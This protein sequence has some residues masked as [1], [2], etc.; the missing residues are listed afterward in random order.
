MAPTPAFAIVGAVNHGKSSVVS[1]LAE[2]D[3]VSVSPMPGE[4]VENK[5]FA[6]RDL[7]VF[8]DTPGFQNARKALEDIRKSPTASTPLESFA[9][10]V[11]RHRRNPEFEA[12]CRLLEPVLG[13]AGLIYVVDASRPVK[14][15]HRCEM[16]LLRLT[17]VPRLAI[18]N[19]AGEDSHVDEWKPLLGQHF[20]A[21]REFDAHRASFSDRLDLLEALA[22]IERAWKAPL[23]AAAQALTQERD[24]RLNDAAVLVTDLLIDCLQHR[25]AAAAD[26]ADTAVRAATSARLI[27]D[28]KRAIAAKEQRAHEAI[29]RLH[30]HSLVSAE[31]EAGGLFSNALF[32]EATW[33]LLGL[34][35]KQLV[36]AGAMAGAAI[37]ASLD[38]LTLGHTLL[39]GS[40][41]GAALG[42]G[43]AYWVGKGR[44]ELSV[45]LPVGGMPSALR[46]LLPDTLRIGGGQLVVGPF[47]ALNF[48]WILIDRAACT[49]AYV[50]TRSHARRDAVHLKVDAMLP[51]LAALNLTVTSWPDVD[52]KTCE[53]IFATLR[54]GKL[55]SDTRR[56]AITE[57]L[58]N[59]FSRIAAAEPPLI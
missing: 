51:E 14:D 40:A 36:G 46:F 25:E 7:L 21:V 24:A 56:A 28:F 35:S 38:V 32:S 52:R 20:N 45:K 8:Y 10:F 23:L 31:P 26:N 48:P 41:V 27:D 3:G 58:R 55:L 2:D 15:I 17:G 43:S 47:Q 29:I 19:R 39:A 37:G 1:A 4:T 13:G 9:N 44:P 6:L 59:A 49:L 57:L 34:D 12:E 53:R 33:K 54:Q 50:S 30:A 22:N 18:L 5:R 16:E 11:H 42:A